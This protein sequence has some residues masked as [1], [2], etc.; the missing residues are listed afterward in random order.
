MWINPRIFP[1]K[2]QADAVSSADACFF[3]FR[4]NRRNFLFTQK[5]ELVDHGGVQVRPLFLQQGQ[6]APPLLLP[7]RGVAAVV[8]VDPG[9]QLQAAGL[10]QLFVPASQQS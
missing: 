7:K 1:Y 4:R 8:G 3:K 10:I 9:H 5:P 2:K 6:D